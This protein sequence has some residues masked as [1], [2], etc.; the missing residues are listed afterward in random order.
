MA[1]DYAAEKRKKPCEICGQDP[2][3]IG[4]SLPLCHEHEIEWLASEERAERAT[5]RQ[6]F[7]DRAKKE[8]GAGKGL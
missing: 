3:V 7:I 2:A 1:R 8:N 6:R 4:M 5:A